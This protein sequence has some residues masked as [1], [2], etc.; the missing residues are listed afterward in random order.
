MIVQSPG[1]PNRTVSGLLL[2]S[3]GTKNHFD[4]GATERHKV[5]TIWG[6]V[7]VSPESEPW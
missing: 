2:G 4:V 7:V 5:Y 3:P 1:S 6:K